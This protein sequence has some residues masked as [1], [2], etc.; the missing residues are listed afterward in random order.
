MTLLR[1]SSGLISL[2]AL[3]PLGK[4]LSNAVLVDSKQYD[5]NDTNSHLLFGLFYEQVLSSC[6]EFLQVIFHFAL[7]DKA[8]DAQP[9]LIG[10]LPQSL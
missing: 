4:S 3:R 6:I 9:K 5:L 7:D 10:L 1:S 8:N 2:K